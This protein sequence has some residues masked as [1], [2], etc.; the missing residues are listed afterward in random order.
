MILKGNLEHWEWRKSNRNGKYKITLLVLYKSCFIVES[1]NSNNIWWD[2]HCIEVLYIGQTII[3]YKSVAIWWYSFYNPLRVVICWFYLGSEKLSMYIIIPSESEVTQSCPTLGNPM[4]YSLPGSSIHGI[5]QA[6][7]ME[8]VAI[9]F[10][11]R[12]TTKNLDKEI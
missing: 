6:R 12:V 7:I 1:K 10:S 3:P 8:W 4:D 5:F 9:S 2:F 11:K